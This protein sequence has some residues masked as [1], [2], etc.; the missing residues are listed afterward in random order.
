MMLNKNIAMFIGTGVL[1]GGA[2]IGWLF[3]GTVPSVD[4]NNG[5]GVSAKINATM[6]NTLVTREQDGVKLWEFTVAELQ[7]D[8]RAN[9]AYLK[10]IKGKVF[11]KD[12]G[13]IEIT[14]DGGEAT[15]NKKDNNFS[16][17]GKVVAQA[18]DGSKF[19]ADRVDYVEK[20]KFIKA[21][22]NV[23]VQKDGYAAWGD[24][25]ETTADLE[26]F[27]LKGHAKVEKGGNIDAK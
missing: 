27:K 7:Q 22:G 19:Y 2:V 26:K 8:K 25:A 1:I 15:L 6:T 5:K 11:R 9:K 12:G 21:S 24:I 23:R 10:G 18:S 20:N 4:V 3:S 13:H 14:A 16:V 17:N